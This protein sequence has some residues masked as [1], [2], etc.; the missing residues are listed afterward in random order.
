MKLN[1][2][3]EVGA[4]KITRNLDVGIQESAATVTHDS[5]PTVIGD[6]TRL[7]QRF[8]NVIG[9]AIKQRTIPASMND[10]ISEQEA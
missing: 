10:K 6:G 5:L 3:F 2:R 9:N 7:T 1:A 8:Q 4:L